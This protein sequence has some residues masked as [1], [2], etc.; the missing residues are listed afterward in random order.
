M[1]DYLRNL[2]WITAAIVCLFFVKQCLQWK[3]KEKT[4]EGFLDGDTA[5]LVAG[6]VLL[7]VL[8]SVGVAYTSYQ[9]KV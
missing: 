1:K 6:G 9:I 7:L 3:S 8:V 4:K 5:G 2:L